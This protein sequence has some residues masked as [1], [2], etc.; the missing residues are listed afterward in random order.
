MV[1]KCHWTR[2]ELIIGDELIHLQAPISGAVCIYY[3]YYTLSKRNINGV[4][5]LI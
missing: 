2:N 3:T 1:V 5:W 4:I